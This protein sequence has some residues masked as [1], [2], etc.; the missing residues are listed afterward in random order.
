MARQLHQSQE[1]P[2]VQEGG[3]AHP[4]T[5]TIATLHMD[6]VLEM[7]G[8]LILTHQ[9]LARRNTSLL[10]PPRGVGHRQS[11]ECLLLAQW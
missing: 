7:V 9:L 10:Q 5:K 3:N 4:E 1:M 2:H 11:R 6:D 8:T